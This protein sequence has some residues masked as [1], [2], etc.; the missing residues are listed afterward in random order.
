LDKALEERQGKNSSGNNEG[1]WRDHQISRL[2]A[3]KGYKNP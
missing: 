2:T 3:L 1:K